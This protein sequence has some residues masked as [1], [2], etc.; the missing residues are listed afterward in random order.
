MHST[1]SHFLNVY[2]NNYSL[3]LDLLSFFHRCG[4]RLVEIWF[5]NNFMTKEKRGII[6]KSFGYWPMKLIRLV[7]NGNAVAE[8]VQ[9]EQQHQHCWE[10]LVRTCFENS[11]NPFCI[12]DDVYLI[13]KRSLVRHRNVPI[14]IPTAHPL[15]RATFRYWE[16]ADRDFRSSPY[17]GTGLLKLFYL[18]YFPDGISFKCALYRVS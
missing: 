14:A 10:D 9:D 11:C 6:R 17:S 13:V 4:H 5:L 7:G 3:I 16:S 2:H 1:T 12:G 15:P 18:I 8:K